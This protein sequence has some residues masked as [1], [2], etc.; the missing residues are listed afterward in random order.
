MTKLAE[1]AREYV[2]SDLIIQVTATVK[3]L[4]FAKSHA[5]DLKSAKTFKI[6]VLQYLD[7]TNSIDMKRDIIN[8]LQDVRNLIEHMS[9]SLMLSMITVFHMIVNIHGYLRR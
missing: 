1:F 5:R 6:Y 3:P 8:V 7:M 2:H 9:V 4:I